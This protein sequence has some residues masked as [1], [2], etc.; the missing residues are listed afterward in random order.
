LLNGLPLQQFLSAGLEQVFYATD[1]DCFV[2]LEQDG[3]TLF[4]QSVVCKKKTAMKKILKRIIMK[5]ETEKFARNIKTEAE[6]PN[7]QRNMLYR[8]RAFSGSC[9]AQ[10][11][12][13]KIRTEYKN[14]KTAMEEPPG[15]LLY[16]CCFFS[17][18]PCISERCC[19]NKGK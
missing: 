16:F 18:F 17:V 2:V 13:E 14:G 5:K 19:Y 8:K 3:D 11:Q 1:L 4:L 7:S 6:F 15:C 10:Q 9:A 12:T